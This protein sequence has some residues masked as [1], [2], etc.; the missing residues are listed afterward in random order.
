[1]PNEVAAALSFMFAAFLLGLWA[2]IAIGARRE[3]R[4][5]EA[6]WITGPRKS[7]RDLTGRRYP[8]NDTI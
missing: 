7:T 4:H 6:G 8:E 3:K 2:G 5:F 1:M